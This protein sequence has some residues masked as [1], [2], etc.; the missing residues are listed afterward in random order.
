MKINANGE[1]PSILPIF[2]V[3]KGMYQ[4]LTSKIQWLLR[5]NLQNIFV[6]IAMIGIIFEF[7]QAS[8]FSYAFICQLIVPQQISFTTI[9][10]KCLISILIFQATLI[11]L[12]EYWYWLTEFYNMSNKRHSYQGEIS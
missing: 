12:T 10:N 3:F 9:E 6:F 5:Q 1:H 4:I 2:L 7:K 8:I 11:I